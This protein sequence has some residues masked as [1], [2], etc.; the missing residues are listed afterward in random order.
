MDENEE[1]VE[2]EEVLDP[3]DEDIEKETPDEVD[4]AL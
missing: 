4:E 3:T 1:K 2:G